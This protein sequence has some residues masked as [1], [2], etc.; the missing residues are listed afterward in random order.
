[1]KHSSIFQWLSVITLS[2][3][4]V[5]TQADTV[6][7]TVTV[8]SPAQNASYTIPNGAPGANVTISTT[9][10]KVTIQAAYASY[11]NVSWRLWI[12]LDSPLNGTWQSDN[13]TATS[14]TT[15]AAGYWEHLAVMSSTQGVPA[16]SHTA[17]G[18]SE[19][20]VPAIGNQDTTSS[21]NFTVTR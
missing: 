16:G 13:A 12:T 15:N 20:D 5:I 21:H 10:H 4:P 11:L 17:I 1:M 14:A 9:G 3:L 6:T 18:Y 8:S 2:L 7:A 19:I